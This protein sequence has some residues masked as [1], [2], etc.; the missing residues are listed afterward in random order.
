M[1]YE[2]HHLDKFGFANLDYI[3]EIQEKNKNT[4]AICLIAG[5]SSSGK[6]FGAQ[7]LEGLLIKNHH[8]PLIISLDSY[9]I[10]LSG[11]IP[12]KV[13]LNYFDN[14][15]KHIGEIRKRIKKIIYDVPFEEKFSDDVLVKI[16][17]EVATLLPKNSLDKF[18]TGLKEEWAKVNFDEPTVYDMKEAYEDIVKLSNDEKINVKKYSKVFSERVSNRKVADGKDYDVIIVEGIYAL[19]NSFI[20][21]FRNSKMHIIT[22]FVDGDAKS[23]FL[24]RVIRD[25]Q[26]TSADNIFTIQLYFKYIL[27]AYYETILPSRSNADIVLNNDMTFSELKTGELYLTKDEIFTEDKNIYTYLKKNGKIESITYQ[28]DIYFVTPNENEGLVK[29]NILRFRLVSNDNGKTYHPS[30]LV[31][32]GSIKLR[33]DDKIIRPINVLLNE[34]EIEKVWK[35]EEECMSSFYYAGFTIGKIEKKIKTKLVFKDQNLTLKEFESI[36]S[37][38]EFNTP[39]VDKTISFI[40][41]KVNKSKE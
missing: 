23:L 26:L 41:N 30:S 35:S 40:K 22:N 20:T 8:K 4:K 14:K 12:N 32:K 28:K 24:R 7:F 9:N 34:D 37:Y 18:I 33:K 27:K 10:G 19:D 6:S 21:Y 16:K 17:K 36:G 3:D 29:N 31:H 39:H 11:I 2:C 1:L 13:N 25:K 5:A 15:L 38:I